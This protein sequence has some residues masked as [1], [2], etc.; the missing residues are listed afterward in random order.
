MLVLNL[1]SQSCRHISFESISKS[2][3]YQ[4]ILTNNSEIVYAL[5]VK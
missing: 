2:I 1:R 5:L 3:A 4:N